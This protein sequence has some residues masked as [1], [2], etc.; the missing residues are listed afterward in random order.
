MADT[1][2]SGLTAATLPLDGTELL[3]VVQ[4]GTS[5]KVTKADFSVIDLVKTLT[6]TQA[7]ST[8]TAAAATALA[9]T[10]DVGTYLVKC[11]IVYQAAATTT[12]IQMYLDHTGTAPQLA[13]TWYTLTTGTTATSGVA[14]Q[15]TTLTAQMMEGKGQRAD[16]VASGPTQGVDTANADQ[17]AVMEG[18]ITVT[19]SGTLNLMFNSEVAASAVTLQIGTSLVLTKVI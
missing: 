5:K 16:G 18:I 3:T 1:K 14:D 8:T 15:A 17:F 7:N 2:I 11:W 4:G 10:V 9:A 12:G 13:A 6:A 19:V